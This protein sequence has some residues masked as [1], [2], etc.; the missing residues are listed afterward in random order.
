MLMVS[1]PVVGDRELLACDN[2]LSVCRGW[3]FV[4]SLQTSTQG[5]HR[6]HLLQGPPSPVL[7]QNPEPR[8]PLVQ[9][10]TAQ[11]WWRQGLLLH[12]WPGTGQL[13]IG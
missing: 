4:F 3:D 1:V 12:T 10:G 9:G 8:S 7:R 11:A 5:V 13:G 6:K 2:N